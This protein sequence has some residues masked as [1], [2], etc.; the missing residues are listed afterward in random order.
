MCNLSEEEKLINK[1]GSRQAFSRASFKKSFLMFA[2]QNIRMT[3]S[4]K[5][6]VR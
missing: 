2:D 6:R 3:P 5:A 4:R 1:N